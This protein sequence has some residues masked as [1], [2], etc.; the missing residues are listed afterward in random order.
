MHMGWIA[1]V[2]DSFTKWWGSAP[3]SDP[4]THTML[5]CKDR[6][7][8]HEDF[9]KVTD[10]FRYNLQGIQAV[11]QYGSKQQ[12]GSHDQ[13]RHGTRKGQELFLNTLKHVS[14]LTIILDQFQVFP[15]HLIWS[16]NLVKPLWNRNSPEYLT[17]LAWLEVNSVNRLL[18]QSEMYRDGN[19]TSNMLTLP[20]P[21]NFITP[22]TMAKAFSSYREKCHQF[23]QEVSWHRYC[24][25]RHWI[26][27]KS[28][29][30]QQNPLIGKPMPASWKISVW[31]NLVSDRLGF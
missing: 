4:F 30:L 16:A 21:Q 27:Y 20:T 3:A 25:C 7:L 12:V 19:A 15:L 18:E 8:I 26:Y 13:L 9:I 29:L 24:I 5:T 10:F 31:I 14:C 6:Q 2:A 28:H 17:L 11:D 1:Q 22:V 23:Y